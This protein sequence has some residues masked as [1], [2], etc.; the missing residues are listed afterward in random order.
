MAVDVNQGFGPA[1]FFLVQGLAKDYTG[2][3]TERGVP[4]HAHSNAGAAVGGYKGA[5]EHPVPITRPRGGGVHGPTK[6]AFF[7]GAKDMAHRLHAAGG[8]WGG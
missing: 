4:G 8:P 7:W 5:G 6:M 3:K 2:G 1:T